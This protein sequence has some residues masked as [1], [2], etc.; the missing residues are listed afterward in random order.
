MRTITRVLAGLVIAAS[1]ADGRPELAPTYDLVILHG[2][3]MDPESGFDGVRAVAITGGLVRAL[4]GAPQGRDTIEAAGLVVAPGFIDLHQHAQS[5]AAYAV[6]ATGGITS[7]FELEDGTGDVDHWYDARAGRAVINYGVAIGE[8]HARMIVM[9]D[10]VGRTE[11]VGDAAH[12]VAT[13]AERA[14]I[15]QVVDRG[16]RRGAVAVGFPVAY[17]PGATPQEIL[18]EFRI[19]ARYGASCHVHMRPVTD[20]DD[21]R[22]I[23]ELLADALLTGA[24]LHVVHLSASTHELVGLYL[25]LITDARRRGLDVTTEM[26]P[27]TESMSEIEGS[28]FDGWEKRPD[29]WFARIEWPPTGERLTRDSFARYR[30]QTGFV[31]QHPP[32]DTAADV[33]VRTAVRDSLPMFASDG[34][35]DGAF[36]HPRAVGTFARVLGR[37]VRER[38]DLTLMDALR[39]MTLEPARR[40][41]RRVPDMRRKGRVRVGADADLTLFDPARVIDRATFREPTLAPEGIPY[42]LVRGVPVVRESRLRPGVAPGRP[43]RGPIR[44]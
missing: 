25:R 9:H 19:A 23:Q 4:G 29:E 2:R 35:L 5:E 8:G 32:D 44:E 41:E 15:L 12:R 3:I 13:P 43:L 33:W 10:T 37:Y 36:G 14:A 6:E 17:T 27:F 18:E 16:L 39:R 1:A 7:A 20:D 24:P 30:R 34:I 38:G 40:L 42:V 31:V 22:D 26:Y 21:I 11:P 28:G